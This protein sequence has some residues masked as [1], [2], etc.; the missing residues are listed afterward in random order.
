MKK[1]ILTFCLLMMAFTANALTSH[2]AT[3]SPASAAEIRGCR[4]EEIAN[5]GFGGA[6]EIPCVSGWSGQDKAS[7]G[8][9][10]AGVGY[11]NSGMSLVQVADLCVK[12]LRNS[13]EGM[14]QLH[15][16]GLLSETTLKSGE[17]E[18]GLVAVCIGGAS[19]YQIQCMR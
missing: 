3:R 16:K 7:C 6:C 9:C 13:P 5:Q 10:L 17:A 14:I 19:R 12:T 4:G 15:Q 11:V 18:N 8:A 2:S 1:L